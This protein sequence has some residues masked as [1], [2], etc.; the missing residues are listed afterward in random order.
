MGEKQSLIALIKHIFIDIISQKKKSFLM[1]YLSMLVIDKVNYMIFNFFA[2][3]ISYFIVSVIC[4]IVLV[5]FY[6]SV[7]DYLPLDTI[8][9]AITESFFDAF[10]V[11]IV[12]LLILSIF[13][14][15]IVRGFYSA[16]S[17]LLNS[18]IGL[19]YILI[20]L[21]IIGGIFIISATSLSI[22]YSIVEHRGIRMS[23]K[24]GI[25]T[26]KHH[27]K[28]IFNLMIV[29]ILLAIPSSSEMLIMGFLSIALQLSFISIVINSIKVGN[30]K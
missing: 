29:F 10:K 19:N 6:L 12:N 28:L 3:G 24:N 8:K 25:N 15:P 4:N 7:D 22:I 20:I 18:S 23:F 1:I 16:E 21:L 14:L 11:A 30:A 9:K 2:I 13:L 5:Y 17:E 26:T 27:F